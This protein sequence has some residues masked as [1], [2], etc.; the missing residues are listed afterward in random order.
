MNFTNIGSF[1]YPAGKLFKQCIV[2]F[3]TKNKNRKSEA[4]QK[5]HRGEKSREAVSLTP[6]RS[7]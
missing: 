1:L 6:P 4:I 3:K 7:D 5:I 2:L